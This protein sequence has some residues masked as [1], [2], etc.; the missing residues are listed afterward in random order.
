MLIVPSCAVAIETD[1]DAVN[2]NYCDVEY[3]ITKYGKAKDV[4]IV[5]CSSEQVNRRYRAKTMR[6]V[7]RFR[8]EPKTINGLAVESKEMKVRVIIDAKHIKNFQI[9]FFPSSNSSSKTNADTLNEN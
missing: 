4:Q 1:T 2:S 7:R 9:V 3:T 5:S 6:F 8:Y